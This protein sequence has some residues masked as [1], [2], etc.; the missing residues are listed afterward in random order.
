MDLKA[1]KLFDLNGHA[2]AIYSLSYNKEGDRLVTGSRDR[3]V[4]VW[5]A[6]RGGDPIML[7]DGHTDYVYG[8][9]FNHDG[10]RIVSCGRDN[11]MKLWNAVSGNE[12][13]SKTVDSDVRA[14]HFSPDGKR[15]ITTTKLNIDV[16]DANTGE[17]LFTLTGHTETLL[18][19]IYSH[20]GKYIA[21]AGEDDVIKIWNSNNAG[22]ARCTLVG[23][24]GDV[25]DISFNPDGSRLASSSKDSTIKLWDPMNCGYPKQ[26]IN[27][28]TFDIYAVDYSPD[29]TML[30]TGGYDNEI[31]IW[32][33]ATGKNELTLKEQQIGDVDDIVWNPRGSQIAFGSAGTEIEVWAIIGSSDVPTPTP[34]TSPTRPSN[35]SSPSYPTYPASAPVMRPTQQL[36]NQQPSKGGN[37]KMSGAAIFGI[38]GGCVGIISVMLFVW[39]FVAKKRKRAAN[40]N[41]K[42]SSGVDAMM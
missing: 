21:S 40:H 33:A 42:F 5:D 27:G 2:E 13:F 37:S 20:D 25:T 36:G 30:A 12:I 23:H 8:T 1:M 31:N 10:S 9:E 24:T 32:N 14:C 4:R 11:T 7:L 18:K 15:I 41:Q 29:G 6:L 26:S 22:P 16:W 38:V 19:A 39:M 35:P 34:T 3:T 28:H 17:D